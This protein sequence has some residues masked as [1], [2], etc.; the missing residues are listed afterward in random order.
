[1]DFML[2]IQLPK[3][4]TSITHQHKILSVGSCFTQHIGAALEDLKFGVL[5]N[6]NGILFD[7]SSVCSSLVS[8]MQQKKFNE[9]DIFQLNEVWQS[10]QHH[11]RFSG[12]DKKEVL[13]NIN[14]SQETAHWFLKDADWLII[15]L[16]SSFSYRLI[17]TDMEGAALP[18]ANC[19]RAPAQWFQKHLMTVT[20]IIEALD[21]TIHQLFYFNK[22]INIIFT[23]SPVRHIRDGVVENNRSKARLIESV[24]HLVNKF[25]RLYYF[26]AYELVIDVLRDYRFY[27][28]D[29]VHPNYLATD[30]VLEKFLET[31]MNEETNVLIREVKRIS[32]ARKH[33]PTH[34]TTEAHKKFLQSN[35]EKLKLLEQHYPFINFTEEKNYFAQQ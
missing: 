27:S 12:V 11:S 28:E 4:A 7:P 13:A 18:V 26:P 17:K 2:D 21:N 32:I 5:Q 22:K 10:W 1:M 19:H 8:Y 15:T 25:D 29:M 3:A 9:E 24:H 33:K 23:I 30:F 34:P 6:P 16:G 35:L 14:Q 20:E 31:Y